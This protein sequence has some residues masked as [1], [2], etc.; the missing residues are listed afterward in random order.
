M[1]VYKFVGFFNSLIFLHKKFKDVRFMY[2]IY[3][4]CE[5]NF[6]RLA[7]AFYNL[8]FIHV[9]MNEVIIWKYPGKITVNKIRSFSVK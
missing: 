7:C 2:I 3:F 9:P 4:M 8:I 1:N 6:N 5:F